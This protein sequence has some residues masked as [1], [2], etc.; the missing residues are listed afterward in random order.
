VLASWSVLMENKSA[1]GVA[2]YGASGFRRSGSGDPF[3]PRPRRP[4]RFLGDGGEFTSSN[5]PSASRI[6]STCFR[7]TSRIGAI[8]PTPFCPVAF[9]F[10]VL[11]DPRRTRLDSFSR[12]LGSRMFMVLAS[13]HSDV[14]WVL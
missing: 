9:A 8:V 6:D 5:H 7:S 11:L 1:M 10:F 12:T 13:S 2:L 4:D 14:I 3:S